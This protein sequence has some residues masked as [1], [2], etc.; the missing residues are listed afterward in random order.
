MLEEQLYLL[1]CVFASKADSHNIRKLAARLGSKSEYLQIICVLW[2][3]LDDPKHLS[4]LCK[5]E[6][7]ERNAEEAE[8]SSED[9]IIKLL[10]GDSR[11]IPL[12]EMDNATISARY[13]ELKEFVINKLNSKPLEDVEDWLRERIMICNEMLPESPLY[14][15]E[16]WETADPGVISSKFTEWIDGVIKPLDHLDKRLHVIFKIN[17]W[18][19]MHDNDQFNLIF[20]GIES[21][22]GNNK[23]TEII[24][25]ELIP[26][27]FYGKK[28]ETFISEFL[29]KQQF[30]LKSDT[31]YKLFLKTYFSLEER[32]KGNSE[33]M[34]NLQSKMVDILFNNSENLFNLSNLL[35]KFNELRDLLRIFPDD[36]AIED[37]KNVTVL[38]MKQFMEFL[39]IAP[40]SIP[41]RKSL[42]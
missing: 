10:E 17:E 42:P 8:L 9:V 5:Q 24:E 33:A 15:S 22:Q 32:L 41:S 20:E 2:P 4:F 40:P 35:H 3:E 23:M 28:W 26:T 6:L 18:N 39:P 34:R 38:E 37:E 29:N 11:L 25:H 30:S 36:I 16:L 13:R 1:A 12:I 31:N 14:Y 27:L 19:E 21:V 7:V